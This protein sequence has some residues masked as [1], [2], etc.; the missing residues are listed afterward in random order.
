MSFKIKTLVLEKNIVVIAKKKGAII[1]QIKLNF[2][3]PPKKELY[4]LS[5]LKLIFFVLH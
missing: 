1:A 3:N 4:T 5:L 2:T